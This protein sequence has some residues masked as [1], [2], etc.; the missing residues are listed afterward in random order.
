[1]KKYFAF[2]KYQTSYRQET[3]AEFTTF[4]T[5]AYIINPAILEVAGIPR[6]PSTTGAYVESAAWIEERAR[7]G[8]FS[9]V[10][11]GLFLLTLIS[12][13]FFIFYPKM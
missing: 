5:M 6:G 3:L 7:T 1:M 13:T 4:V 12:L 8:F 10:T 2:D 9:L 11:A